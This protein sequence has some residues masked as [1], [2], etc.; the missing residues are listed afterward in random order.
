MSQYGPE[1]PHH[2]ATGVTLGSPGTVPP[3][4]YAPWLL[5]QGA[6]PRTT[7]LVSMTITQESLVQTWVLFTLRL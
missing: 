6:H 7:R 3:A 1:L 4:D 2:G 5:G